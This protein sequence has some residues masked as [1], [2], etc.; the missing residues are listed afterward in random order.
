MKDSFKYYHII[1]K[2]ITV[3]RDKRYQSFSE[4]VSAISELM[5]R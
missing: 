3:E 2:M 5:L 1:E 4:I